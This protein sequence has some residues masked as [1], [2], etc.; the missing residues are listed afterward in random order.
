M[1]KIILVERL[2]K[3]YFSSEIQNALTMKRMDIKGADMF[4][5]K[6]KNVMNL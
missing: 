1:Q 4:E 2:E 3:E 5:H 6:L